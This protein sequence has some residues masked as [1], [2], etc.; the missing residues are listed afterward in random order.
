MEG[1]G[2]G[3]FAVDHAVGTPSRLYEIVIDLDSETPS[4]ITT[5]L[6]GTIHTSGTGRVDVN[7]LEFLESDGMLYAA[8]FACE[9][10]GGIFACTG[11]TWIYKIDP[12]NAGAEKIL[13]IPE[14]SAGDVTFDEDDL[15]Y[16]T[17]TNANLLKADVTSADPSFEIV[18]VTGHPDLRG[19]TYGGGP[20][21]RTYKENG[22]VYGTSQYTATSTLLTTLEFN[23]LGLIWG[24]TTQHVPPTVLGVMDFEDRTGEDTVLGELWYRFEAARN[25][26]ITAE[27]TTLTG[28]DVN[29]TLY[30]QIEATGELVELETGNLRM[31]Y[32]TGEVDQTYFLEVKD[33]ATEYDVRIANLFTV[34]GNGARIFGTDGEDTFEFLRGTPGEEPVEF[35]YTMVI[36][37]VEYGKNFSGTPVRIYFEG[38]VGR[39]EAIL[40]GGNS[41]NEAIDLDMAARGG[42]MAGKNAVGGTVYTVEVF[43]TPDI[44][45]DGRLGT[46]TA[47]LRGT[48]G[49]DVLTVRF[50]TDPKSATFASS[51]GFFTIEDFED[52]L[53]TA[54]SGD[55]DEANFT[56]TLDGGDDS[57]VAK[58]DVAIFET[59]T[60]DRF[61]AVDFDTHMV[62]ANG[63]PG[64]IA[65]LGTNQD[66]FV[67]SETLVAD[68]ESVKL[69]VATPEGGLIVHQVDHFPDVRVFAGDEEDEDDGDDRATFTDG[70][71]DDALLGRQTGVE[72]RD[73]KLA[74]V[75]PP[76]EEGRFEW[77]SETFT[78]SIVANGFPEVTG[79]SNQGEDTYY[80]VGSNADET[81]EGTPTEGRFEGGDIS[82]T[83]TSF[84]RIEVF[85]KGGDDSATFR[86]STVK[87][88][89]R[90]IRNTARFAGPAVGGDPSFFHKITRAETVDVYPRLDGV[91]GSSDDVA[92]FE[93]G[94]ED[95][96]FNGSATQSQMRYDV[97]DAENQRFIQTVYDFERTTAT[98]DNLGS[99]VANFEDGPE[100][101]EFNGSPTESQ[102]RF[103][104]SGPD[105]Q[106]STQTAQ[107]F[108]LVTASADNGGFD[109]ANLRKNAADV[110]DDD[111]PDAWKKLVGDD[112]AIWLL[113]P[114]EELNVSTILGPG[115][116]SS[117]DDDGDAAVDFLMGMGEPWLE[118]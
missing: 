8:G 3:L 72:M 33:S 103:D 118:I 107:G 14:E 6:V 12:G 10:E 91:P 84:P 102:M 109:V 73:G 40:T 89:F 25:G 47:D 24:A 93:D 26:Y 15:L 35:R 66:R 116:S 88:R 53:A 28:T 79:I 30:R 87:D 58:P 110:F 97:R 18:G 113:S 57:Y 32:E 105:S 23:G 50:D 77:E 99:D 1:T 60:G 44:T 92:T 7:S 9:E 112:Y 98:A 70:V 68:P 52:V 106:R 56:G 86:G 5:R 90:G 49:T 80:L 22:E 48:S 4:V 117:G 76:G 69:T 100:D 39:D 74:W 55:E 21:L 81:Y 71:L 45:A 38:G 36:N 115:P 31:D 17:T 13:E 20:S 46:D 75:K 111:P 16:V 62:D 108:E 19:A 42:T 96:E 59:G 11:E 67:G 63:S 2:G 51:A 83:A 64:D 54:V 82:Y 94:P 95:D 78:Y 61:R 43:D 34:E 85:P 27:L 101:D 114:F 65:R 29:F 41:L 37:G 104:V